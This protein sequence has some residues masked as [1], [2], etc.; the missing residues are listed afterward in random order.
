MFSIFEQEANMQPNEAVVGLH[1][2]QALS[3]GTMSE[4]LDR[5][6]QIVPALSHNP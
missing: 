3:G 2:A 4:Q 6:A 5:L 1:D